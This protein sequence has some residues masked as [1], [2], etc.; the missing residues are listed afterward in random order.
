M[1]FFVLAFQ[2]AGL[3]ADQKL[4]VVRRQGRLGSLNWTPFKAGISSPSELYMAG[5]A[6]WVRPLVPLVPG[7]DQ[8]KS[9][10]SCN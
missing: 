10:V 9:E 7:F 8:E 4:A 5:Y 2:I 3:Q 6:N 1:I